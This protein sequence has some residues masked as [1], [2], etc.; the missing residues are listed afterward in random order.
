MKAY[1]HINYLLNRSCMYGNITKSNFSSNS[2]DSLEL[3]YDIII[4]GG[5]IV[6]A[7]FAAS[8][9][10]LSNKSLRI[11]ILD[12]MKKPL[13]LSDC[14]SKPIP[15]PRVY[16]LAPSSIQFLQDIDAWKYIESRSRS[17]KSMQI[18]ESNGSG[19]VRF[20]S[21]EI[22]Q[23]ELGCI[24]EDATVLSAIYKIIEEKYDNIHF[25][26]GCSVKDLVVKEHAEIFTF[27][28]AKVTIND[29][30]SLEESKSRVLSARLVVGAD[31][32][33]ST[34]RRL[35]NIST[36]GWSY[37]QEGLV[38][39]V[40]A[41][42][43][44]TPDDNQTTAYQRYLQTGP[45][46]LLPL[47]NGYYSIVWSLP[48]SE[49]KRLKSLH[50]E[51]FLKEL[52]EA[53]QHPSREFQYQQVEISEKPL[54][55]LRNN[56][57]R[58]V[59]TMTTTASFIDPLR[60][61]PLINEISSSTILSFPLQFQH[62]KSYVNPRISLIGDSAHSIHPQAGQGLN[63]GLGDARDLADVIYYEGI[64][65][66][67]DFG[68]MSVLLKY[69]NKRYIKNLSMMSSVDM[70]NSIFKDCNEKEHMSYTLRQVSRSSGMLGIHSL[71][72]IKQHIANF[73]MN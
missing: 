67:C 65:K 51:E 53:F 23:E 42:L 30:S 28:P 1:K 27:G 21:S 3:D 61:P 47:W 6:A 22:H 8:L 14:L 26:F 32:A 13:S 59:S 17:Y 11:C 63:L 58:L 25:K 49:A 72:M 69:Q 24:A 37:G 5:S 73:A 16:A 44:S 57:C 34:V 66:G 9:S 18:W 40:R 60:L 36:F 15:D 62:V 45:I 19:L 2:H 4:S 38:A 43:S 68:D 55:F 54:T 64:L 52:N 46:A 48:V 39:T 41:D 71:P 7:A 35:S 33:Q 50:N 12:T 20:H 70:I 56:I 29:P 31:G 10:K